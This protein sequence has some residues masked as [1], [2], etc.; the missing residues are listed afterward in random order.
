MLRFTFAYHS[1]DRC[2]PEEYVVK[3][4]DDN[5]ELQRQLAEKTAEIL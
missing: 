1:W 4:T 5:R 3:D 2:V